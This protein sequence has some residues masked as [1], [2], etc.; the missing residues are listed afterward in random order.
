[1]D[2]QAYLSDFHE[3]RPGITEAVL[4]RAT[5]E[6]CTGYDW[7]L[8][9]VPT[10][11]ERPVLDLACGSAPLE[12]ALR[13]LGYLG[14]DASAAELALARTKGAGGL[15]RAD[16]ARLPL[17]SDSCRAVVCSMGLQILTPLPEVLREAARVLVPKGRL[18]ALLPDHG[19][20]RGADVLWLAGLMAALGRTLTYPNSALLR[21]RQL[22]RLLR[23][24]GLELTED[25]R[26]RFVHRPRSAAEADLFLDSLYVPG[27]PPR[28]RRAA[29]RWL[30]TAVRA[31]AVLPVPLRRITAVRA[32]P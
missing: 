20:L 31:H 25:R 13:G 18:V 28:R 5:C 26:R 16:A 19:P 9:A 12:P 8:E 24:A 6:G 11:G 29:Q 4:R 15:V 2:W 10:V 17:P 22:P 32:T 30:H 3:R 7:L 1:M 23:A 27:L 21:R 14:V